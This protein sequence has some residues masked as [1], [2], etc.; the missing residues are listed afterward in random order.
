MLLN[1]SVENFCGSSFASNSL[2]MS[3]A[4]IFPELDSTVPSRLDTSTLTCHLPVFG[5]RPKWQTSTKKSP[6]GYDVK[7]TPVSVTP[8]L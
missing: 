7:S 1:C 4:S 8:Y 5:L 3:S 2:L 6:S